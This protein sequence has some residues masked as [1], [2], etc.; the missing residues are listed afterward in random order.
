MQYA[1][2]KI[3]AAQAAESV[4]EE[5]GEVKEQANIFVKYLQDSVPGLISFGI[6]LVFTLVILLIGMKLIKWIRKIIRRSMERA[7]VDKG[8][9]QFIDALVKYVL[10]VILIM[11]IVGR[12]GIA[13]SSIIA[14]VGSA[15]IAVGMALQGSLSNLAGGVIILMVKPFRVGDYIIA[16][17]EGTVKEISLVYTTLLTVDNK[18]VMIPNGTLANGNITNVT[19]LESRR[20]DF[21][22]G[23]GYNA[24]LKL[25]KKV[26]YQLLDSCEN[27]ISEK[28]AEVFVEDLAESAVIIGGR[29]WV[30]AEEYWNA[31]WSLTEQIKL[32]FDE[33]GI[34]IP[35]NQLDVHV[36]SN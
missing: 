7:Q 34:E 23:I 22:I 17:E 4:Q 20:V 14:V 2:V 15:G 26:M 3:E 30:P 16:G 29:V 11:I 19:A 6:K 21:H 35:F 31:R 1:L 10:Y 28:A 5:L 27:R 25:A 8:V 33:N 12:F 24:D 36:T 32:A 9:I 18:Q 13:S